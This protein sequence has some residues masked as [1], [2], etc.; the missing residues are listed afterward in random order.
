MVEARKK[1]GIP[2][3][4]RSVRALSSK[5]KKKKP[6]SQAEEELPAVSNDPKSLKVVGTVP[7]SL[8]QAPKRGQ[9]LVTTQRAAL[10]SASTRR[11]SFSAKTKPAAKDE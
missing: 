2:T 10:Y 7:A 5:A 8:L 4:T 11:V 1:A 9:G 6:E 3:N